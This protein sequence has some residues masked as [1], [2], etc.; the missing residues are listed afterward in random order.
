MKMGPNRKSRLM[1]GVLVVAFALGLLLLP[2]ATVAQPT[3]RIWRIGFISVTHTKVEDSFFQ[4][5]RELGYIE[6]QNLHVERRYS[7]GQAERFAEFAAAFAR[8]NVDM[9]VVTTTPAGLTAKKATSKIPIVQPNSIDPVGAGLVASLGRPGGNFT[10]TTQH[11]PELVPK[12]LQLLVETLGKVSRVGVIWN[13]A[14]P[15]FAR[16]WKEIQEAAPAL[17]IHVQSREVRGPSDF[18]RVFAAMARDRPSALLFVGDQLTLQH[19]QEVVDFALQKRIPSMFDRPHLVAAG[20]LMSYGAD[21]EESYRRAAIIAD[22]ILRG[23]SPADTPMEQPTKFRFVM[24]LKTA[25][26]L[27]LAIPQSVLLRVDEVIQ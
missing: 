15:A 8:Q 7:E 1:S 3:A 9:I 20:G 16:P 11:A 25:R 5:L 4:Q 26:A 21:E 23:A 12:R 13:A 17:G 19:G 10:G 2:A 22:K 24:N 14:N 27:G 18:E 6:G